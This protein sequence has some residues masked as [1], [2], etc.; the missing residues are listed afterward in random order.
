MEPDQ[1]LGARFM[2]VLCVET[3]MII[4]S[5]KDPSP[6]IRHVKQ[7]QGGTTSRVEEDD[8]LAPEMKQAEKED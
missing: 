8:S 6:K 3:G 2:C 4:I 7:I 1:S 5:I